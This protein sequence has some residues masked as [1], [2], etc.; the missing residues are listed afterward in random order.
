MK[1]PD[2]LKYGDQ[3]AI[4]SLSSGILGED[5]IS[6][7][8]N[9]GIKRLK[10]F[11]LEPVFMPNALKGVEFLKAILKQKQMILKKLF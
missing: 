10:E 5:F 3:V 8:F 4:V 7:E 2:K 6:H 11:G 1:K 9:L